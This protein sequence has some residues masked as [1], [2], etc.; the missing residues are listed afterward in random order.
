M[1][2]R[3]IFIDFNKGTLTNSGMAR[4][5]GYP[6]IIYGSDSVWEVH[7]VAADPDTGI[8]AGVDVT[9]A[10]AWHA[11]VDTD[12]TQSTTPMIRTLDTGIDHSQAASG[13]ISVQLNALTE[14]FLAKVDGKQSI[15][16]YFELRGLDSNDKTIYCYQI[17]INALGA[18][19]AQGGEPIPVASGGVTLSDV[20]AV[21]RQQPLLQYSL[22]GASWHDTQ[23][24]TD[25]LARVSVSGGQWSDA[26]MLP[27]G[28]QGPKGPAG[29]EIS[30]I[31]V[32]TLPSYEPASADFADG[33]LSLGI[34]SGAPGTNGL[35][36]DTITGLVVNMIP[37]NEPPSASFV[38]GLETLW[39]PSGAQGPKGEDGSAITG[40]VVETLPDTSPASADFTDGL[41]SFGIPSGTPGQDGNP[42]AVTAVTALPEA[43]SGTVGKAYLL[44]TTGHTYLGTLSSTTEEHEVQIFPDGWTCSS[45][46]GNV[47]PNITGCSFTSG[48]TYQ[49]LNGQTYTWYS[50][51]G[52]DSQTYYL[53]QYYIQ[54][55]SKL[56]VILTKGKAPSTWN[57]STIYETNSWCPTS[58]STSNVSIDT[59]PT[60]TNWYSEADNE[61]GTMQIYFDLNIPAGALVSAVFTASNFA[62]ANTNGDYVIEDPSATGANR[63]WTNGK[64]M[65][66]S[67]CSNDNTRWVIYSSKNPNW[68]LTGT[69]VVEAYTASG[70]SNPYD[71]PWT[72]RYS[73]SQPNA[74]VTTSVTYWETQTITIVTYSFQ[75]IT[76][77]GGGGGSDDGF[78][79]WI[80]LNAGTATPCVPDSFMR[81]DSLGQAV[82]AILIPP[83][84]MP[85]N[86]TCRCTLS[87]NGSVILSG[88][89]YVLF[90]IDGTLSG[91][92]DGLTR[93]GIYDFYWKK[94]TSEGTPSA[95]IRPVGFFNTD[96]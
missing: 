41:L 95:Y 76:P 5:V 84:G 83:S 8:A 7:L 14:N 19:D 24:D 89:S 54:T 26:I 36:G 16:A 39:I 78:G 68:Q 12:F 66:I 82:S 87:F 11:A 91:N 38:G 15:P 64:G 10:T 31:I 25:K 58:Y 93:D 30:S 96:Q 59:L 69:T 1:S 21:V 55:F 35:N 53:A 42:D 88:T 48:G 50:T 94:S 23:I 63:V 49:A 33:T 43:T 70:L 27:S 22:D 34:P 29:A 67:C 4:V 81:F 32:T 80:I 37:T 79:D 52:T 47:P 45:A 44:T 62:N 65:Y 71:G 57:S 46:T 28:A 85:S 20:Y 9:S 17:R 18:V 86:K 72:A 40:V 60:I 92:M 3:S 6:T 74:A 77:A 90:N 13:I 2:T 61:L 75:D 51:T 73:P 56:S